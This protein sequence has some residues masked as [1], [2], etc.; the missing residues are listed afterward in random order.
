MWVGLLNTEVDIVDPGSGEHLVSK[1]GILLSLPGVFM[2]HLM[3]G[4]TEFKLLKRV[5]TLSL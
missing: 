5:Y 1:K 4:S 2:S 3:R